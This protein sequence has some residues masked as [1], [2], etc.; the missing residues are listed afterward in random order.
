MKILS[1]T[2][3]GV[4]AKEK[5][6]HWVPMCNTWAFNIER[7]TR[8]TESG[9][10]PYDN[11]ERANVSLLAGAAWSCGNIALEEFQTI[12]GSGDSEKNGRID[13][14]L[15]S[16][17]SDEEYVEAKF[18]R[19]SINGDYIK[20]IELSLTDAVED[21]EF[22]RGDDGISTVGVSFIVFFMKERSIPNI[23][24]ALDEAIKNVQS[25]IEHDLLSWCYPERDMTHVYSDGYIVPGILMIAKKA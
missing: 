21:A 24:K 14:W 19:I 16:E 22:S 5:L 9:D 6:K 18:K 25:S 13:L 2:V 4:V 12:K 7:Y 8:L 20:H 23:I 15:C 11:N 10:A 3:K 17:E 1:S